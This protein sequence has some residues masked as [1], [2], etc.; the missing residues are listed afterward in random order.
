MDH[1]V[2]LTLSGAF[3]ALCW[4][5]VAV[6]A[7]LGVFSPRIHDTVAER[8]GLSAL[9]ITAVATSYRSLAWGW[10]SPGGAALAFSAAAYASAIIYKH[11]QRISSA[12]RHGT[13]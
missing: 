4:L 3:S 11:Y 1:V 5:I 9:S 12:G 7:G 8:F 6:A 2:H 10:E 13:V